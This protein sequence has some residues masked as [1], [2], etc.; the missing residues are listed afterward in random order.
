LASLSLA[1]LSLMDNVDD[2]ERYRGTQNRLNAI[3]SA[4]LGPETVVDTHGNYISGG[5]L[6]DI[7]WPPVSPSDL[8][9][10]QPSYWEDCPRTYDNK[11]RTFYGWA[12]PYMTALPLR[13]IDKKQ[14]IQPTLYDGCVNE[15]YGWKKDEAENINIWSQYSPVYP[16]E[17]VETQA[18]LTIRSYGADGPGA[19]GTGLFDEDIPHETQPLVPYWEWAIDIKNWPIELI[20]ESD[21]TLMFNSDFRF[22]IVVPHWQDTTPG[23]QLDFWPPDPDDPND[24]DQYAGNIGAAY[25][26]NATTPVEIPA[27]SSKTFFF[28][29]ENP[30]N[31]VPRWVPYGRRMLF[32][33]NKDAG[34]SGTAER[35]TDFSA[36]FTTGCPYDDGSGNI[37]ENACVEVFISR[38][39]SKGQIKFYR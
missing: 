24:T 31:S 34:T 14:G 25:M 22:M 30:P 19:A 9:D 8:I 12:G 38:H 26:A 21:Q 3:R 37:E 28:G 13:E 16:H 1:T 11:W 2:K 23:G 10:P 7:G 29:G 27:H 18:H 32:I 20:N 4:I 15:F 36:D 17:G 35:F 5:F 39:L 33:V 6:Q